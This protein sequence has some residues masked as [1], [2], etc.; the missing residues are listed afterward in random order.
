MARLLINRFAVVLPLLLS[1]AAFTLVLANI[2]AG[3]RPE[4]DEGASA[5]IWQL[6]MVAQIPV[7][8]LFLKTA[9]WRS[10]ST[11]LLLALQLAA[12]VLACVPVW[13]AGY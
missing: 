2:L 3:V 4:G 11:L 9:D 13:V 6:L 1:A 8:L 7:I 10:R 12:F 5:H